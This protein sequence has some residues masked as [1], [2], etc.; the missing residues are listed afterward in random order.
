MGELTEEEI[1]RRREAI[2]AALAS[3]GLAVAAPVVDAAAR[4][5][6]DDDYSDLDA[7]VGRHSRY[8]T[9]MPAKQHLPLLMRDFAHLPTGPQVYLA[10]IAGETLVSLGDIPAGTRWLTWANERMATAVGARWLHGRN[11]I[12]GLQAG[13]P[14]LVRPGDGI[15]SMYHAM[16]QARLGNP[17]NA[18]AA[19][20]H[21]RRGIS[22]TGT[23]HTAFSFHP[24]QWHMAGSEVH[25]RLGD[26]GAAADHQ[27]EA[28]D[29]GRGFPVSNVLDRAIVN[30]DV[31]DRLAREGKR[32]QARRHLTDTMS[33]LPRGHRI[34]QVTTRA[35]E[36][37][38]RIGGGI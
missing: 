11:G 25:T 38:E 34:S 35:A 32:D 24:Y 37:G 18:Y 5:A 26:P 28:L 20:E 33:V 7:T 30:V 22:P 14:D 8:F 27:R 21:A 29:L 6:W 1:M 4:A 9:W 36:V 10:G 15:G 2:R 23:P 17:R 3:A 31:A 16:A 12:V 19:L 13:R